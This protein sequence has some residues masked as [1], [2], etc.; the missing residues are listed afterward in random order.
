MVEIVNNKNNFYVTVYFVC[1]F[2]YNLFTNFMFF[3]SLRLTKNK[4]I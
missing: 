1:F 2:V 4:A 3:L